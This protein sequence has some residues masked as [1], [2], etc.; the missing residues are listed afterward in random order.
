MAEA[1]DHFVVTRVLDIAEEL[2]PAQFKNW[3]LFNSLG[4]G[5]AEGIREKFMVG[6]VGC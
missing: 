6:E 5:K 3:L 1:R 2:L 4:R